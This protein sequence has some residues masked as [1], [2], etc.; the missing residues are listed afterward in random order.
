M[1]AADAIKQVGFEEDEAL[2]PYTK[3]SFPGYRL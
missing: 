2:L 1:P 3:R